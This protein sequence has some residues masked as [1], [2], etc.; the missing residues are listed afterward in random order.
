[1]HMDRNIF[2]LELSR[3]HFPLH[4]PLCANG[5]KPVHHPRACQPPVE[6]DP[7][8]LLKGAVEL[9]ERGVLVGTHLSHAGI[10]RSL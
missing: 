6:R 5:G 2:K 7:E 10:S 9:M 4:P 8:G 3:G 1:M